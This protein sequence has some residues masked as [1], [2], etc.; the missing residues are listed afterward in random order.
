VAIALLVAIVQQVEQTHFQNDAS[1]FMDTMIVQP[2]F[3]SFLIFIQDNKR[4]VLVC[5]S[6]GDSS[7]A[8]G[9]EYTCRISSEAIRFTFRAWLPLLKCLL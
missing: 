2:N 8:R 6:D 4:I 1:G 9:G 7:G 3:C 5:Y